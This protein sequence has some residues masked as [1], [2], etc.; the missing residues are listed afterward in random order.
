MHAVPVSLSYIARPCLQIKSSAVSGFC[1]VFDKKPCIFLMSWVLQ[2]VAGP[3]SSFTLP[4]FPRAQGSRAQRLTEVGGE[5]W[6]EG[7]RWG[8]VSQSWAV[9]I[10]SAWLRKVSPFVLFYS[11]SPATS[12]LHPV[13]L[14][15]PFTYDSYLPHHHPL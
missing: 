12:L 10:L 8:G 15:P 14:C 3:R 7:S 2:T 9:S 5:M 11:A 4:S 13:L 6:G 1:F